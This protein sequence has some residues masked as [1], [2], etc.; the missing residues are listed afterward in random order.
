MSS[1]QEYFEYVLAIECGIPQIEMKGTFEDWVF[2]LKKFEDMEK[3]L[4]PVKEILMPESWWTSVKVVLVNLIKTYGGSR[5]PESCQGDT[6]A[7][8]LVDQC[9]GGPSEPYQ[10]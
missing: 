1:V 2:L 6:D 10:N 8:I 5:D 9:K 4:D 7:R 3:L